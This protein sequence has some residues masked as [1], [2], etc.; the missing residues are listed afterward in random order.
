[1]GSVTEEEAEMREEAREE[2]RRMKR[3][4]TTPPKLSLFSR[5]PHQSP[6]SASTGMLTPPLRPTASVPFRWEEAPG[7]PLPT[8]TVTATT[9][10]SVS[11]R[12]L[13]LPPRLQLTD[14]FVSK[15]KI[16]CI[17][18]RMTS[19][20]TVLDGPYVGH[21]RS[22]SFTSCSFNRDPPL[23]GSFRRGS[24]DDSEG[25]GILQ[26]G[27]SFLGQTRY[28]SSGRGYFGSRVRKASS[29]S[30]KQNQ[31]IGES[32]FVISRSSSSSAVVLGVGLGEIE[33]AGT[34]NT[35]VKITRFRRAGSFLSLP[36]TKSSHF[37][38][39]IYQ[40]FKQVVPWR[41]K[42]TK[43]DGLIV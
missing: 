2:A 42:K 6:E 16:A 31:D 34:T 8:T 38:A 28:I 40:G 24:P 21:A 32:S 43:K 11:A 19:P 23:L 25:D 7:K 20:T 27:P 5:I 15:N 18:N 41:N 26:L 35:K 39:S 17:S 36:Y 37:W 22:S 12:C 29:A 9:T 33:G 3:R 10:S 4:S 30:S 14:S 13:E 1:M